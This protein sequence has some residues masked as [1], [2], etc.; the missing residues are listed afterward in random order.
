MILAGDLE[1]IPGPCGGEPSA[2]M[3]LCFEDE[4]WVGGGVQVLCHGGRDW[5][6]VGHRCGGLCPHVYLS[7]TGAEM[8]HPVVVLP[9]M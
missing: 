1:L 9:P 3:T 4:G 6:L 2:R 8:E 5:W 7:G